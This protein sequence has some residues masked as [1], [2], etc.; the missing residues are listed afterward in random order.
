MCTVVTV[1]QL[2]STVMGGGPTI[3]IGDN[4][5]NGFYAGTHTPPPMEFTQRNIPGGRLHI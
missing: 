4:E 5:S 3:L 2:A 1:V